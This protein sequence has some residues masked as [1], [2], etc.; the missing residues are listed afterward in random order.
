MDVP[1]DVYFR[2]SQSVTAINNACAIGQGDGDIFDS[3]G[4]KFTL[5]MYKALLYFMKA[6]NSF[7]AAADDDGRNVPATDHCS[8][9]P[10]S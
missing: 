5:E 8:D 10:T 9:D 2:M 6:F 7:M 1:D 3:D 4:G